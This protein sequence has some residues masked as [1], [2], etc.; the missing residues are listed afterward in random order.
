MVDQLIKSRSK[1]RLLSLGIAGLCIVLGFLLFLFAP[2][3]SESGTAELE[4]LNKKLM[5][6]NVGPGV[7]FALFGS[8]IT[9]YSIV[10]QAKGSMEKK[11][12]ESLSME[13]QYLQKGIKDSQEA[14]NMRGIYQRDFRI[15]S[16][17]FQKLEQNEPLPGLLK[18]DFES[19]LTNSK[20]FLMRSVWDESWGDYT[21]FSNWL[22]KGCPLPVPQGIH[23]AADFFSGK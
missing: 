16:E 22:S 7:F 4:W 17:V 18:L 15:F 14:E 13:F 19:A 11:G 10:T 6:A 12:E 3:T 2:D 23:N 5:L 20:D 8:A 1:E 21:E 9:V